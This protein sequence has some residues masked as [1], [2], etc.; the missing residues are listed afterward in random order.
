LNGFRAALFTGMAIVSIGSA[1]AAQGDADVSSKKDHNVSLVLANPADGGS[2]VDGATAQHASTQ[3]P[4]SSGG[5]TAV[6][7]VV[8]TGSRV[9]SDIQNSPTP[10][11]LVTAEQL[12]STT[13]TNIP[14]ALNKLPVFLGS[15]SGRST[16]NAG[17]NAAG[18]VLNLRNFGIQRTLV[19]LDGHRVTPSNANGTVDTD[20]LPTML[21]SRVDVV[22]GGA[23]A[24]YGS[25]AVTGVVNFVLDKKFTGVKYDLNAGISKYGDG[26]SYQAGIAAGTDLFGGRGHLEGSAR[27]FHQ[28]M[29]PI[30]ARPYGFNGQ[31]WEQSGAGTAAS[32]Y[33]N[34][35]YSRLNNQVPDGLITCSAPCTVNGQQFI[36]NG[37]IGPF[38]PGTPTNTGGLN[39]GGDGGY[40]LFGTYQA[41]LRTG[42]AF[43]RFS[44]D[45][46]DTTTAYVQALGAESGNYATWYPINLSPGVTAH[47]PNTFFANNAYLTPT[48]QAQ[49]GAANPGQQFSLA[50][51]VNNIDNTSAG[52]QKRVY[53]T[54]A[55]QRNLSVTAGV[56]GSAWG[57]FD[58][59]LYY[60]HGESRLKEYNPRNTNNQKLYAAED[61]VA[62][63]NGTVQCYVSTT[64]NAGLYPGCAPINPFGPGSVTA[65][66]YDYVSERTEFV[67]TNIMDN[68][69]GSI[70]GEIFDL[71]A[72][73]VKAALSGEARWN[74]YSVVSNASPT[75]TVNCAGLRLCDATAPLYVQNV[76]AN[77]A[78]SND[79]YEFAGEMNVPVVKDL[80]L[81]QSFNIDLAGRFT[82]YST[83]GAVQTWKLGFDHHVN[84]SIRFRGTMSVDIRAPTLND[85]FSPLSSSTT[86]F[87]DL[88]TNQTFSIPLRTQGNANLTPEVAHTYTVGAVF[89]PD[90]VPGLT[91]SVD[92]YKISLSNGITSI[93]Y[94]TQAIQQLC[95]ASGGSSPY[96]SLAI[97][98]FPIS[99]TTPA[100]YPT[101]IIS[102]NLNSSKVQTEG[103]DFEANYAFDLADVM[104]SLPGSVNL[105][106]F[107][108][109]QPYISQVNFPGA[110]PTLSPMPKGRVTGFIG[111]TVGSWGINL[112][113]TWLSDFDKRTL[114][115]QVFAQPRVGSFDTLDV[116]IDKKFEIEG[117][118]TDVYF[119]V[120]NVANAQ[121]PLYPTN[122]QNP[123]LFYPA[124]MTFGNSMG[125]YFTIGIR[126]NL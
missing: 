29:I 95:I 78:A 109:I 4:A 31:A 46:D 8:V 41:A 126:G 97:R 123:G 42:E 102:Q 33:V 117:G 9:I 30:T 45:L 114:A 105:R 15:Q 2:A 28:D 83:S 59:D 125:R 107:A 63:A 68:I 47:R 108:S 20:T 49:L 79:V 17:S 73:P 87:T 34:T 14:E 50:S 16:S 56:T 58:W 37:I 1:A 118:E 120:Q 62:G 60:T 53:A 81:V 124:P 71:P 70:S 94:S 35:Q 77:V 18:N 101:A 104:D 64:A 84:D 66:Q 24:V 82:N 25:D 61:A 19:L 113:N 103:L 54:G 65:S 92:Y 57:R 121:F 86:G 74:Q 106:G 48:A 40:D 72:G 6:E 7:Q 38:N 119:T 23:S 88:L 51:F 112:Q 52:A 22:T 43:G 111:Y 75:A 80:P 99:N 11:T 44:Y 12:Q 96:C 90:F 21:M 39:N 85:L 116:T 122:S 91:M 89:T 32:P 67:L 26:A 27:Y 3:A 100:N 36:Q 5:A 98:P 10:L 93:N 55:V 76:V 69:G 13:P 115:P 110:A